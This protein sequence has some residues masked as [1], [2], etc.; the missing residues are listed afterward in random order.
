MSAKLLPPELLPETMELFKS[1]RAS[2]ALAPKQANR[3]AWLRQP[4][5]PAI[6]YYWPVN[7]NSWLLVKPKQRDNTHTERRIEIT[8]A[9]SSFGWEGGIK[10]PVI[11]RQLGEDE[12]TGSD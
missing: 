8:P 11:I 2:R 7:G 3:I 1:K 12:I 10:S 5:Q 6:A 9:S 4:G